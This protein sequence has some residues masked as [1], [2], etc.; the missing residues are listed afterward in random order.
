MIN[1][2]IEYKNAKNHWIKLVMCS[3]RRDKKICIFNLETFACSGIKK[4]MQRV[5]NVTNFFTSPL[6]SFLTKQKCGL[7]QAKKILNCQMKNNER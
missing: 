7:H 6:F 5:R 1:Y 3:G 2:Y 4:V